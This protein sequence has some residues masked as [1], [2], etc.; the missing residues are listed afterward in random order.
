VI[1][2]VRSQAASCWRTRAARSLKLA[3]GES[4]GWTIHN[5]FTIFIVGGIVKAMVGAAVL[6]SAWGLVR[7]I[8]RTSS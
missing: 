7:R 3:V 4:W 5:G 2:S 6:P 8:E 1:S